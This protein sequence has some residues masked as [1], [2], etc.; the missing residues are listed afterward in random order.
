MPTPP[1]IRDRRELTTNTTVANAEKGKTALM[2]EL[3]AEKWLNETERGLQQLFRFRALAVLLILLVVGVCAWAW[4]QGPSR[5]PGPPRTVALRAE[6]I[7]IDPA[8]VAPLRMGGAWRL[9]ADDRRFGGLSALAIDRGRLLALSDSGVTFRFSPPGQGNGSIAIADLGDGP[10]SPL[11]KQY[12]DSESMARDP[13]GRGWWVGF[14][15]RNTVW[16][17]DSE[18]RHRLGAIDFGKKRW[19]RNV[20][21]EAMLADPGHLIQLPEGGGERVDVAQ[22]QVRSSPLRGA[23]SRISDTARLPDGTVLVLLRKVGPTGFRNAL[24]VL[25]KSGH[26]WTISRRVPLDLGPFANAEGL[27]VQPLGHGAT[28]LWIVTDDNFQPPMTT[29][30]FALDVP[31]GGWPGKG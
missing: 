8:G 12:R 4:D 19:P 27:A 17:Y 10:G 1:S 26:G 3:M 24:G 29:M 23:D 9:T 5:L 30:L 21:I 11:L 13:F 20:G 18:L 6:R 16:L 14:E 31:P 22:G 7:P 28:R 25:A 15:G 2:E